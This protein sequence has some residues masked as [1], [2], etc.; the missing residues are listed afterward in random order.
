MPAVVIQRST[1]AVLTLD[2]IKQQCRI[3][4]DDTADDTLLPLIERAAVASAEAK[5]GGPVLT[6]TCRDTLDAWPRL[7][8]LHLGVAGG[9]EVTAITAQ[10]N[11]V[12]VALSLADFHITP[13]GRLLCIKPR[14]GWPQVDSQPG[15]I[16]ID[17]K[18]GFGEATDAV[19]ED[20][21][22]WLRFRIATLYAYREEIAEGNAVELPGNVVDSLIAHY[23]PDG[24]PL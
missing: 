6:A 13:D 2:D 14:K 10:Q 4:G 7:P 18:A 19:P 1:A 5:I 15:A 8:W 9:R 23:K 3:D 16:T 12:G 20:L 21:R 24:V 17:Y 11:G 22:Q